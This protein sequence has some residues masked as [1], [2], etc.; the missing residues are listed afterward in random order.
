MFI[1]ISLYFFGGI[2]SLKNQISITN[3]C[4]LPNGC[5][6]VCVCVCICFKAVITLILFR[7]KSVYV[8]I[9]L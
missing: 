2:S 3:L 6:Y 4:L 8:Y 9:I 5:V 1:C 7:K